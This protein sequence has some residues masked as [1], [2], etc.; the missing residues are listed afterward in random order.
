M[1]KKIY[2]LRGAV[3]LALT[4]WLALGQGAPATAGPFKDTDNHWSRVV[5]AKSYALELMKGYPGDIFRPEDPVTRLEAIAV[6]INALGLEKE[7]KNVDYKNSGIR[8]PQGM[9]WGQGHLVIAVQKGLLHKDYVNQLMYGSPIPRQEMATLVAVALGNKIKTKGDPGKLSYT[10][11]REIDPTYLPYVADVT[12]NNIMQG[13]GNNEF[14][15]GQIMRRGQ[16]AA[17]MVKT[18]QEG[19]FEYG[20][21]KFINGSLSAS[22]SIAGVISITKADGVQAARLI[23]TGAVFYRDS[24]PSSLAQFKIGE[25]VTAITGPGG[26]VRY[27]EGADPSAKTDPITETELTGKISD[28]ALTGNSALKIRDIGLQEKTYPLDPVIT[29]TDGVNARDMSNVTDGTYVRVKIKNN[30]IQNIRILSPEEIAGTI[31]TIIPGYLTIK[32]DSGPGRIF[33]VN[34]G[35]IKIVKGGGRLAY[36]GLKSGDRVKII[37]ASGE[38]LEVTA[39]DFTPSSSSVRIRAV[40]AF[41][42]FIYVMNDNGDRREYEVEINAPITK[43]GERIKIEDL[44]SGDSAILKVG[45]NG[46]VYEIEITNDQYATLEGEVTDVSESSGTI[47]IKQVNGLSFALPVDRNCSCRDLTTSQPLSLGGIRSGW[48]VRISLYNGKAEEIRV[49][50]K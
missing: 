4:A 49:T 26:K 39:Q 15:P 34:S 24:Q 22:D 14:G 27:L 47:T 25:A 16:M 50:S 23:D 42:G 29:I 2:L 40:D 8:L 46:K 7:T 20:S 9:F 38:A 1:F 5:V 18:T 31:T 11:T 17:L 19:W 6:I 43:R 36:S 28:R 33:S 3:T 21:G 48:A 32:T 35:E 45:E 10:D 41:Y 44:K 13:L 12:Q 30:S 37:A